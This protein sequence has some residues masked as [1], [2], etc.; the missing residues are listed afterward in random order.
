MLG[1]SCAVEADYGDGYDYWML[2]GDGVEWARPTKDVVC[3]AFCLRCDDN[4]VATI[5]QLEGYEKGE[6]YVREA[7]ATGRLNILNGYNPP[8]IPHYDK[9]SY[10]FC[11]FW[12]A[13][14]IIDY[15]AKLKYYDPPPEN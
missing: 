3:K 6:Y 1:Q 14:A 2:S 8:A 15:G 12:P 11:V 7:P 13:Y 5:S 4:S 10:E 9:S